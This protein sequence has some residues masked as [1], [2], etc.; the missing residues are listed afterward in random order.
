MISLLP[1]VKAD[2]AEAK[3]NTY[4]EQNQIFTLSAPL[5]ACHKAGAHGQI[6]PA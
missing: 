1:T 4:E 6:S 3:N 5:T 2:S